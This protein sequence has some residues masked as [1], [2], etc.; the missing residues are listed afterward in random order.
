MSYLKD[1]DRNEKEWLHK[2]GCEGML[3]AKENYIAMRVCPYYMIL[4]QRE[5]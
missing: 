4:I 1:K 5:K 2:R 3:V